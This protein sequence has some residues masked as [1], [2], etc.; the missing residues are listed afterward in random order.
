MKRTI[1][2]TLLSLACSFSNGQTRLVAD[3]PSGSAPGQVIVQVYDGERRDTVI[4]VPVVDGKVDVTFPSDKTRRGTFGLG[5]SAHF[6]F[7]PGTLTFFIDEYDV[8]RVKAFEGSLTDRLS[9]ETA[10][11]WK[12]TKALSDKL[13]ELGV[14]TAL[15]DA[16]KEE[17]F[18][19]FYAQQRETIRDYYLSL[20][21]K[22]RDN[23]LGIKAI[24]SL[25]P[26]YSGRPEV[27]DSLMAKLSEE[28]QECSYIVSFREANKTRIAT[29][30]GRMFTDF[31]VRQ[32]DGTVRRLSDYVGKG[33]YILVDFWASW[34][35]P[36]RE[37][38]PYLKEVWNEFKGDRFDILGVASWDRPANTMAAIKELG[39]PWDQILDAQQEV[40]S[41]YGIEG[42]PHIILFAPDGTILKRNLRGEGIREA[43]AG[44]L[45][46]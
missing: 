28:A 41:L 26:I 36:C 32:P 39:I 34:C 38:I 20:L 8:M 1:I 4:Y 25:Q 22:N 18:Q 10:F 31:E 43:V 11:R 24:S 44:C 29:A 35:G 40:T 21:D 13:H 46:D 7:E 16:R 5:S 42:I 37:E 27:L 9:A 19:E 33:K 23:Y 17:L 14:D 15:D 6:I 2:L 3:F 45:S 12:M 30:E